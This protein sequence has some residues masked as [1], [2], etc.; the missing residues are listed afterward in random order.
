MD[1][2]EDPFTKSPCGLG[3]T[4]LMTIPGKHHINANHMKFKTQ[5]STVPLSFLYLA[6][7]ATN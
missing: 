6:L 1:S 7:T 5:T 2:S 3:V 4:A